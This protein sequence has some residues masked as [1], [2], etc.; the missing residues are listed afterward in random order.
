MKIRYL[1]FLSMWLQLL[2]LQPNAAQKS[3]DIH[4]MSSSQ[5]MHKGER[6]LS[7]K[8]SILIF[9][10]HSQRQRNNKN[11]MF[12]DCRSPPVSCRC[13]LCFQLLQ[14]ILLVLKGSVMQIFL[15][16]LHRGACSRLLLLQPKNKPNQTWESLFNNFLAVSCGSQ[17]CAAMC[18]S[19][20]DDGFVWGNHADAID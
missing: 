16:S 11:D 6:S 20:A 13:F 18:S 7:V 4:W 2:H 3:V 1:I 12:A 8:K 19:R 15:A 10:N 9:L 14:L 17:H 5:Q